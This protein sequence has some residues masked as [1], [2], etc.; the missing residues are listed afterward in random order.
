MTNEWVELITQIAR[1]SPWIVALVIVVLLPVAAYVGASKLRGVGAVKDS[2]DRLSDSIDRSSE[3]A[4]ELERQLGGSMDDSVG[5]EKELDRAKHE[6][7]RAH[8]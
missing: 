5:L 2:I 8:V 6:I 1:N 4:G 3:L 7:G